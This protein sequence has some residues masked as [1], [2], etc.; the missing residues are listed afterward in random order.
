M[1]DAFGD[2]VRQTLF[3]SMLRVDA[4]G[5]GKGGHFDGGAPDEVSSNNSIKNSVEEISKRVRRILL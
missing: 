3:G 1:R 4:G 2:F 5:T